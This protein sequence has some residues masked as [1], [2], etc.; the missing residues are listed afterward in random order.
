MK[1]KAQPKFQPGD[2]VAERPKSHFIPNIRSEA[3]ARIA[4][5]R[6]QR[7]GVVVDSVVKQVSNR[8]GGP[9]RQVYVRVLWDG[10]QTPSEHAQHRLIQ[11]GQLAELLAQ[12]D[13]TF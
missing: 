8:N 6:T 5:Y 4:K 2:R 9:A 13:A 7:Y 10:M 12:Y 11:E 3:A 1:K